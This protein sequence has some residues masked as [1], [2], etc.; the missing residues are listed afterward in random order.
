MVSNKSKAQSAKNK[1]LPEF[2]KGEVEE[3]M[4]KASRN[5]VGEKVED[6]P[7]HIVEEIERRKEKVREVSEKFISGVKE[8]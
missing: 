4:A 8:E 6:P 7:A 3:Y 1:A 5:H 2:E